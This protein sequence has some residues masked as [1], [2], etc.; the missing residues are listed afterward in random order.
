MEHT[1]ELGERLGNRICVGVVC[2]L[3]EITYRIPDENR[4]ASIFCQIHQ[5]NIP[6]EV[7]ANRNPALWNLASEF[8]QPAQDIHP[9]FHANPV[10]NRKRGF[11]IRTGNLKSLGARRTTVVILEIT[12]I[13]FR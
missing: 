8:R 1:E 4:A 5:E 9:R 2:T 11:R 7:A 6:T 10:E 3:W 13:V 12:T